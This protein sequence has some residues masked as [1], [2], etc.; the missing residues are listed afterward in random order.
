MSEY[1]PFEIQ[2]DIIKRLPVKSLLQFRSV[3]KQWK[4]L[5]DS[6]EFIA[7]YRFRQTHPQRLL[8]WYK[9]PV[10]LKQKYVSFVDDDAFTQQELAPTFPVLSEHLSRLEFL[11]SSQ[12]LLCLSGF[13]KD[14][15]HPRYKVATKLIV[16]LNPS[17]R[18]SV[19]I[20][21]PG[22]S[23]CSEIVVGFGVCPITNDPTIVKITN[24][25]TEVSSPMFE[26]FKLSRGSWRTPCSN[27]PK[28]SIEVIL[29]E[30]AIH[31]YIYW[32]AFDNDFQ[33]QKH[34]IIS[35]DMTTEEFRVI[36]LPDS[37]AY[38]TFFISKLWDSLVV[39]EVF[40]VWIMDND[41]LH[42]FTKLFTIN[43]RYES[44]T[45]LGFTNSGEPMIE[46]QGEDYEEPASLVVYEPNSEHIKDIG[47]HVENVSSFVSSYMETLLLHDQS[48]CSGLL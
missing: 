32:V 2:V 41:V 17:I 47:I 18:K 28:K 36:D 22:F 20:P 1:I 42:S 37:L 31:S 26:V 23:G 8:V 44:I 38:A 35:F 46:V 14:P 3:S 19:L 4:S 29:S 40:D 43:T 16:L 45:I 10:D 24:V 48:D 33:M 34:V 27:L 6:S 30:V 9:D 7:G 21:V 39:L 25:G 13:Y 5:I 15:D 11:G 12:G